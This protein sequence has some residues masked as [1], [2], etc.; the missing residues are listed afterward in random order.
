M[1]I[2]NALEL[3]PTIINDRKAKA[4]KTSYVGATLSL[5][6][7]IAAAIASI[8]VLPANSLPEA[9]PFGS[10]DVTLYSKIK[11]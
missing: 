1:T 10:T 5:A 9:M 8:L 3:K 2:S 11:S 6:P 7:G 4:R